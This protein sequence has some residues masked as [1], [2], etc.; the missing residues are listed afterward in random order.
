MESIDTYVRLKERSNYG[1]DERARTR[2]RALGCRG[3]LRQKRGERMNKEEIKKVVDKK[4]NE[5]LDG[6]VPYS[7]W[8]TELF[9]DG[10]E[11]ALSRMEV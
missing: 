2:F 7:L 3:K 8:A 6:E 1:H 10:A 5:M 9:R 11:F 4:V